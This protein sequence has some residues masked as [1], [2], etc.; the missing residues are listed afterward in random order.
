MKK[1]VGLLIISILVSCNSRNNNVPESKFIKS[2]EVPESQ[3]LY[4]Y[5]EKYGFTDVCIHSRSYFRVKDFQ[6]DSQWRKLPVSNS[7][8]FKINSIG[9]KVDTFTGANFPIIYRYK[10]FFSDISL[11]SREF[12]KDTTF[13][14]DVDVFNGYYRV[15]KSSFEIYCK[16][17]GTV[18]Y[19]YHECNGR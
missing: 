13:D 16:E 12:I 10:Y 6:L 4:Q 19:E 18:Y 9:E 2:I 5:Y 17:R 14:E 7:D 8:I 1:I 3:I 15:T 11:D